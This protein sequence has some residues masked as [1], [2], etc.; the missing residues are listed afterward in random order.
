MPKSSVF[1]VVGTLLINMLWIRSGFFPSVIDGFVTNMLMLEMILTDEIK[2]SQGVRMGTFENT[3]LSS[4]VEFIESSVEWLTPVIP[5][6]GRLRR[7]NGE[8]KAS[9]EQS[10]RLGFTK[11][12]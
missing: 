8:F 12:F 9:L 4:I 2:D 3:H 11:D 7:E 1:S 6:P 5:A 10:G